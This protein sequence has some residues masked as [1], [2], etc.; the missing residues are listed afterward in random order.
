MSVLPYRIL[1]NLLNVAGTAYW[2]LLL[3]RLVYDGVAVVSPSLRFVG[4][5]LLFAGAI[6]VWTGLFALDQDEDALPSLEVIYWVFNSIFFA[7]ILLV[8]AIE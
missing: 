2:V 4:Y 5:L 6:M 1:M 8:A 3:D 7:A